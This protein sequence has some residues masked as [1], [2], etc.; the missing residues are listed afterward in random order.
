[1][2]SVAYCEESLVEIP[3]YGRIP[4]AF[5]V[6]SVLEVDLPAGGLAGFRFSERQLAHPWIKDYDALPGEGPEAWEE[7]WDLSNWGLISAF[8]DGVR[9][10]GCVLA[11]DTA[12]V[13]QLAGRRDIAVVWDL[14]IAPANRRQG[15]G[16][17]LLQAAEFWAVNRA[18]RWLKVETQNI[19]VPACRLYAGQGFTL[20]QVDRFAY[21]DLPDE[22]QL[23]WYKTLPPA[24]GGSR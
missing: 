18:C 6:N 23:I 12:G 20:G 7:R 1:M 11:A 10:G 16:S 3:A 14:R 17:G 15:I 21:P 22:V 2:S 9:V 13:D 19:N 24:E 8:E 4:I 5:E